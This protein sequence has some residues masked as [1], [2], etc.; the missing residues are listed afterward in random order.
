MSGL[1]L[2]GL[3]MNIVI[4]FCEL[5]IRSDSE[6]NLVI[7]SQNMLIFFFNFYEMLMIYKMMS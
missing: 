2:Q 6:I 7:K 3:N 4:G 5:T 1:I